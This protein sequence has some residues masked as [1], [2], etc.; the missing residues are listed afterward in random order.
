MIIILLSIHYTQ[1]DD[2]DETGN[3]VQFTRNWI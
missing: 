3:L 1:F 2:P